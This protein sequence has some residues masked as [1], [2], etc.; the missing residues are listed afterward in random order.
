MPS[1]AGAEE[2]SD[3]RAGPQDCDKGMSLRT[4]ATEV[5]ASRQIILCRLPISR[6]SSASAQL[7]LHYVKHKRVTI[8]LRGL[9]GELGDEKTSQLGGGRRGTCSR[10]RSTTCLERRMSSMLRIAESLERCAHEV[11]G[12]SGRLRACF[13]ACL[14][15]RVSRILYLARSLE[16]RVCRMLGLAACLEHWFSRM[17]RFARFWERRVS[18][19]PRFTGHLKHR[20]R[21]LVRFAQFSERRSPKTKTVMGGGVRL[22][23]KRSETIVP[24]RLPP[25][26]PGGRQ[27]REQIIKVNFSNKN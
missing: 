3:L 25:A 16:H 11:F 26:D 1:I 7:C 19:M 21:T 23:E 18:R 27:N 4:W 22:A 24:G 20:V 14:E 17:P 12:A 5:A 10:K 8:D 13:A 9:R 15:H 2:T 6:A